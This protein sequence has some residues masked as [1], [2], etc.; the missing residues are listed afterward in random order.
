MTLKP[1]AFGGAAAV[2]TGIAMLSI[3]ILG[4]LGL[5]TGAVAMMGQWHVFFNLSIL[6][7]VAGMI[8]GA[9]VSFAGGYG[10][11]ALYNK[12]EG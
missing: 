9:A 5:Y 1:L 12:L 11:A 8:E 3:G 4:N 7:I 10:F 2:V 6:G